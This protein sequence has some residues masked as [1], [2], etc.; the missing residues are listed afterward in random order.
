M[1]SKISAT[2]G[3]GTRPPRIRKFG[4]RKAGSAGEQWS[5]QG[6]RS[7]FLIQIYWAVPAVQEADFYVR[8]LSIFNI[9]NIKNSRKTRELWQGTLH[10]IGRSDTP[11]HFTLFP[12]AY[13]LRY[14]LYKYQ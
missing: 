2:P 6:W 10:S 13:G 8:L 11:R 7:I 1:S 12:G 5:L 9:M 3:V 14:I 4:V